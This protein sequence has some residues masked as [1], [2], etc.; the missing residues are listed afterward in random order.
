MFNFSLPFCLSE[1]KV[2]AVNHF[3]FTVF[4]IS[5]FCTQFHPFALNFTFLHW[6]GINWQTLN[7]SECRNCCLYIIKRKTKQLRNLDNWSGSQPFNTESRDL[8]NSPLFQRKLCVALRLGTPPFSLHD[9]KSHLSPLSTISKQGFFNLYNFTAI[10]FLSFGPLYLGIFRFWKWTVP[11]TS[12][13]LIYG[14]HQAVCL[15]SLFAL[16]KYFLEP[17]SATTR[18]TRKEINGH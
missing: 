4:S 13:Y 6:F 10:A 7:Q 16:F 17:Y 12:V 3:N 11:W 2:G 18:Q 5:F 8:P 9:K 15:F 14:D 1:L